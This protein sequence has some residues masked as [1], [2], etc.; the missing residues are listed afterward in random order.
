MKTPLELFKEMSQTKNFFMKKELISEHGL[1]AE[2]A[3]FKVIQNKYFNNKYSQFVKPYG[4]TN[5]AKV[6][7]KNYKGICQIADSDR[8]LQETIGSIYENV[9]L[10]GIRLDVIV[11][12]SETILLVL[13]FIISALIAI[14]M[15]IILVIADVYIMKY[16]K[17]IITM[18]AIGYLKTSIIKCCVSIPKLITNSFVMFAYFVGVNL[19]GIG[20]MALTSLGVYIPLVMHWWV[21]LVTIISMFI[22]FASV[23]LIL[24]K[25]PMNEK[26]SHLS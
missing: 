23:Y 26:V 16:H 4:V 8:L 11:S 10:L 2:E 3:L 9:D 25:K 19:T 7:A 20:L 17:F 12:L 14:S 15:L 21:P 1:T 24:L 5:S 22:L 6:Y 18:K 13:I